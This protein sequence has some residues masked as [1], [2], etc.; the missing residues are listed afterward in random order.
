[1]NVHRAQIESDIELKEVI[2]NIHIIELD[3]DRIY[4]EKFKNIYNQIVEFATMLQSR[5]DLG[6]EN[7]KAIRNILRADRLMVE[8]VRDIKPLHQNMNT[9]LNS[10]N[11]Y[12]REEYN[13]LRRIVLKI[14][15]LTRGAKFGEEEESYLKNCQILK[16]EVKTHDVLMNGTIDKLVRDHLIT[17]SMAT[18][19]MNDS[20]KSSVI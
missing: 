10:D 20:S 2:K 17:N 13:N 8:I 14:V 1:L 7:I 12:I 5:F 3:V 6:E 18:S 19:L 11:E 15:R 16:E 9:Y 4:Y